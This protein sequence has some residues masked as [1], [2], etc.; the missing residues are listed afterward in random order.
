M[1]SKDLGDGKTINI[2]SLPSGGFSQ[3]KAHILPG[4]GI[5]SCKTIFFSPVEQ[6]IKTRF[7]WT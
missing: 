3:V 1:Y 7:L 2:T 5:S 6:E 4:A